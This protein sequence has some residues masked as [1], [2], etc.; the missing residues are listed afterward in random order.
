MA[1]A[2]IRDAVH[3]LAAHQL[4]PPDGG[5]AAYWQSCLWAEA[6]RLCC[7]LLGAVRC[8]TAGLESQQQESLLSHARLNYAALAPAVTPSL[9][10]LLCLGLLGMVAHMMYTQVFQATVNLGPEDWRPHSWDYGWAF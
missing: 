3:Q 1:V 2:G 7:C 6:Q 8:V 4:H 5:N 10:C 9:F